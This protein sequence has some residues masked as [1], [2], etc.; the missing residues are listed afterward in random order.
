MPLRILIRGGGDL[1]SGAALRLFRAGFSILITEVEQPLAVRRTVSFSEAVYSGQISVEGLT[2]QRIVRMDEIQNVLGDGKI[3]VL[4]D[5]EASS[6][7]QWRPH[8]I[9]DGRMRKVPSELTI[10]KVPLVI[11][12][13]PGFAAGVDCHAVIE[14][15]RGPHLGRVI[16]RGSASPDTGIPERVGAAQHERVLR[17]PKDGF[18]QSVV[19]IGQMVTTGSILADVDGM[20]I[21]APF[22]GLIRGL[23]HSGVR[24]QKGTKVGDL[25]PRN[26][27]KLAFEISDKALAIGGAVLEA[28]LS[29][30]DLRPLLWS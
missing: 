10:D 7:K 17:A 26:D 2:A 8:V 14:T 9:V 3:A 1:S 6:Q 22:S 18:F 30:T 21:C 13:G 29:R 12:L 5:P 24:V 19:E 25:D 16:W 23:I 4:V 28:I 27:R 20:E 11:G 15:Q